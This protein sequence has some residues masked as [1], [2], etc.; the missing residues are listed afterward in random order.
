MMAETNRL[1][2]KD[3][4]WRRHWFAVIVSA[5]MLAVVGLIGYQLWWGMTR[6]PFVRHIED[7][8]LQQTDG[9]PFRFADTDGKVR[10]VAFIY[11]HCPD[12]CP[13]T[14]YMMTKLQDELK[15]KGLYGSD[16]V[17]LSVTFDPEHDTPDV[18][19]KYAD[20]YG[21]DRSG[22]YFLRGDASQTRRVLD[23]FG[24]AAEP[25]ANGL[26]VHTM[27]TFLVD[28]NKNLRRMYGMGADLNLDE[29]VKDIKRLASE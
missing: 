29:M 3:G 21:A 19:N 11:T 25:Q 4:F 17:F 26:Y 9:K 13:A 24:V 2:V 10:L 20:T 8:S 23:A 15:A 6:L 28:K 1:R 5:L 27:R 7:F 22:W 16:A 12:V 18:L 14:T